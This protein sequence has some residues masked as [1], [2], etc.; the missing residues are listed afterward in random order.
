MV[1]KRLAESDNPGTNRETCHDTELFQNLHLSWNS[2]IFTY[3]MIFAMTFRICKFNGGGL[4]KGIFKVV[5]QHQMITSWC[6]WNN[7]DGAYKAYNQ[8]L[9]KASPENFKSLV[10]TI[11]KDAHVPCDI[12]VELLTYIS[13]PKDRTILTIAWTLGSCVK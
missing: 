12:N 2:D 10:V 3:I 7:L 8:Y 1:A 13:H 4:K 9:N 5:F 6:K 11:L